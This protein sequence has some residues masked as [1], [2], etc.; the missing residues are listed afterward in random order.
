[1]EVTRGP[2]QGGA[3]DTAAARELDSRGFQF[4]AF[5]QFGRKERLCP[6]RIL[7]TL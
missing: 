5:Q 1:M 7:V 3:G 2:R 6:D 4:L